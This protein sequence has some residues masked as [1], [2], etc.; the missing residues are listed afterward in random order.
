MT[1]DFQRIRKQYDPGDLMGRVRAAL[2]ERGYTTGRITREAMESFDEFHLGGREE[3]RRLAAAVALPENT[4]VLDVGCGLGGPARTLAAEFGC[5]V[6]GVDVVPAFCQTAVWLSDMSEMAER[7]Q[8][9]CASAVKLPFAERVF[10]AVMMQ[11]VNMNV[12]DK[13]A[14]FAG[15][16]RVLK[17]G[18][19]LALF[20]VCRTGGE[21]LR[22][23]VFWAD[24]ESVSFV[25]DEEEL[26]ESVAKAGF[27]Q[28]TW[29]DRSAAAV[30]WIDEVRRQSRSEDPPI[31]LGLVETRDAGEKSKSVRRN[32]VEGWIKVVQGEF[33]RGA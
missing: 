25:V 17:P 26:Q 2:A 24:N 16:H 6:I 8:F 11:L 23:P 9:V 13:E 19:K 7:T 14:L 33:E 12:R 32:L 10:D 4:A 5:R 1:G 27:T 3:T 20:E 15:I 22:Y 18:G 28:V 31:G 29:E 30:E 21:K